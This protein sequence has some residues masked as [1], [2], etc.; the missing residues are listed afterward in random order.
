MGDWL[1]W[2]DYFSFLYNIE[3][4]NILDIKQEPNTTEYF[5]EDKIWFLDLKDQIIFNIDLEGGLINKFLF[6]NN[7]SHKWWIVS[8]K[9]NFIIKTFDYEKT[10]N[11]WELKRN[12]ENF[13]T[14]LI[15]Y[16]ETN[17]SNTYFALL[18]SVICESPDHYQNCFATIRYWKLEEMW[19]NNSKTFQVKYDIWE[20]E[21]GLRANSTLFLKENLIITK[22]WCPHMLELS[23]FDIEN[24]KFLYKNGSIEDF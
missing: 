1:W 9:P 14:N 12:E 22:L 7:K 6:K 21:C 4:Q 3:T 10:I 2:D 8:E 18:D 20:T 23:V 17:E 19:L 24:E 11:L 15:K 13:S 5:Y 16:F